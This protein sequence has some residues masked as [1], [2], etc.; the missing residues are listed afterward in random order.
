MLLEAYGDVL[1]HFNDIGRCRDK[2]TK[3]VR[4]R[5]TGEAIGD[6]I[7]G[8]VCRKPKPMRC[9]GSLGVVQ[10]IDDGADFR[11]AALSRIAR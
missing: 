11:S 10:K 2:S 7:L 3:R 4:A 8:R 6:G 5:G 1:E 9:S